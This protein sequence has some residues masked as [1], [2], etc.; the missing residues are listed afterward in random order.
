MKSKSVPSRSHHCRVGLLELG[1]EHQFK[2]GISLL[3]GAQLASGK[4]SVLDLIRQVLRVSTL[5][6]CRTSAPWF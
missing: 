1:G 4:G 2:L 6:S 5:P 3:E